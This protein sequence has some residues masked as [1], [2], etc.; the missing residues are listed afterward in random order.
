MRVAEGRVHAAEGRRELRGLRQGKGFAR[1]LAL[2]GCCGV[3]R[4]ISSPHAPLTLHAELS[5]EL[6]HLRLQDFRSLMQV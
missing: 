1:R 2:T 3:G 4:I 5:M 6:V